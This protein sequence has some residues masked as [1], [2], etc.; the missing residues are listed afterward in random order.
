MANW[1]VGYP[2]QTDREIDLMCEAESE[3]MWEEQNRHD[4]VWNKALEAVG[5]LNFA[6]EQM[7]KGTVSL[8]L[9]MDTMDETNSDYK[10]RGLYERY[11]DLVCDIRS[12]IKQF[13][14][15]DVS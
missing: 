7:E 11:E 14:D 4:E 12:T 10:V 9:A 8:A 6:L 2:V 13:T 5:Y 1:V 3:K 15:G